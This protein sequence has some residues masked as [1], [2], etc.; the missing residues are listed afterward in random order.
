MNRTTKEVLFFLLIWILILLSNV[1][2]E[3]IHKKTNTMPFLT[4]VCISLIS[5]S[6]LYVVFKYAK[7]EE[8]FR[9]LEITPEKKCDGGSYLTGDDEYCK[10]K[11]NSP[12]GQKDLSRYNCINGN[13]GGT[14]NYDGN[15]DKCAGQGMYNGRPL[16]LPSRTPESNDNW[17]NEMCK[18]PILTSSEKNVL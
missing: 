17:E 15:I 13:C 12:E 7:I 10:D 16:N 5:V 4:L 14:V 3:E 8:K 2:S 11:W 1:V 18:S 9:L 6:I